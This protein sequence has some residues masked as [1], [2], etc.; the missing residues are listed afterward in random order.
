MKRPPLAGVVLCVAI[1]AASAAGAA[2]TTTTTAAPATGA[3]ASPQKPPLKVV[4]KAG[5]AAE[6]TGAWT[7]SLTQPGHPKSYAISVTLA[8]KT[9]QT[10]YP[11]QNCAGKLTRV[12][13]SG[14]YAFFTETISTGKFDPATKAGCLDGS[15]T[16]QKDG[17]KLVMAWMTAHDG[18]A[19]VAYGSLDEQKK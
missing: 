1:L 14:N 18:K 8:G 16:L 19:I 13:T 12:G 10:T 3:A 6:W 9:G 2:G 4:A 17:G 7:G 11:D 15:L 5:A